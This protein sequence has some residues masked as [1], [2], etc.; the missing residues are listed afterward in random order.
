MRI[1]HLDSTFYN[2][3]MLYTYF[4]YCIHTARIY[5]G[6]NVPKIPVQTETVRPYQITL[7]NHGPVFRD[8]G[9]NT[10]THFKHID[11]LKCTDDYGQ[12]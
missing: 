8:K 9:E 10:V 11:V 6:N 7:T 1:K 5:L 2:P 12:S 3:F 4:A